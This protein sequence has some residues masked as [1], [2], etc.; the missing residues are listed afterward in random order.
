[1]TTEYLVSYIGYKNKWR[2]SVF[3]FLTLEA[4]L[5]YGKITWFQYRVFSF[6]PDVGED[7]RF[8]IKEVVHEWEK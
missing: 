1:M 5:D 6:D 8:L 2:D 7:S 3:T 4:A